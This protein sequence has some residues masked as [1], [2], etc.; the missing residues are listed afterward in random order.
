MLAGLPR[1]YL[2]LAQH[3]DLAPLWL[4]SELRALA[5]LFIALLASPCATAGAPSANAASWPGC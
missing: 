5:F 3:D 1:G 4:L 2:T